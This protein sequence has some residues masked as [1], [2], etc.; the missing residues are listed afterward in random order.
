M[1]KP[2]EPT[3]ILTGDDAKALLEDMANAKYSPE[4]A[5]FLKSCDATYERIFKRK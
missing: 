5:A 4:K 3:P 2:I 1:A